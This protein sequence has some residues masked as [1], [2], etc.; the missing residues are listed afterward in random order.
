MLY[1]KSRD[2]ISRHQHYRV[3]GPGT[4][5]HLSHFLEAP[6]LLK[7]TVEVLLK[8]DEALFEIDY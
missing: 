1:R 6:L 7:I 5:R 2:K 8:V 3:F 4:V